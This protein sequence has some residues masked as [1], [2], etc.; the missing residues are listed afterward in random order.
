[1]TATIKI[2]T[3]EIKKDG[4]KFFSSTANING[5]WFKIKFTTECVGSPRARGL[6]DLT[7][8]YDD[9]SVQKGS[10]YTSKTG[11]QKKDSDIIWVRKIA[12]IRKYSDEELKEANRA[13]MAAIFEG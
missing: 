1:M 9:C 3:R 12:D 6:Y 13:T 7:V 4:K 5:E 8:D 11:E 2:H 10:Y